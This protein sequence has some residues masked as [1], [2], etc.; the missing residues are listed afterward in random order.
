MKVPLIDPERCD[1]CKS[2]VMV[3]AIGHFGKADESFSRIR[4]EEFAESPHHVPVL[5]MACDEAPC[6]D[7]CPMNARVRSAGGWVET[8]PDRCIGC[9]A[10]LY[11]CPVAAP[12]IHP[13]TGKSMS[14]DRCCK[15]PLGAWCEKACTLKGA[16]R[17][18]DP[19][20]IHRG[21]HEHPDRRKWHS[22][23]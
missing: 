18:I 16:I 3:C 23:K 17:F 13:E 1:G 2:C 14:C 12:S 10:C 11:I 5:C 15:D 20:Q 21:T 19:P 9:R 8:D 4:I 6:I 7:V 22:G